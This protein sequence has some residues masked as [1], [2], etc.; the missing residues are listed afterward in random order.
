MRVTRKV[1]ALVM[2]LSCGG[3]SGGPES[4]L[5]RTATVPSLDA[6]QLATLCDWINARVGGYGRV[7]TCAGGKTRHSDASQ[8]TCVSGYRD[9]QI[10]PTLTVGSLEDCIDAIGGD[11]C[12]T[13][14]ALPCKAL[15]QCQSVDGGA[16]SGG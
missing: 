9:A 14:T 10:C 4:G 8:A 7:D 3:G 6:N 13:D 11:L 1:I 5:P 15:D 12:R 16:E 2:W